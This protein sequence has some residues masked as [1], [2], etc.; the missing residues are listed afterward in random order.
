MAVRIRLKTGGKMVLPY[1]WTTAIPTTRIPQLGRT[2]LT[3]R[4]SGTH[5]DRLAG[6]VN[7]R[8]PNHFIHR[9][10]GRT[11]DRDTLRHL[12]RNHCFYWPT[13]VIQF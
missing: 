5:V 6:D 13:Q 12:I 7:H 1:P 9:D 3:R 4:R 2:N 8:Q 11:P 10:R